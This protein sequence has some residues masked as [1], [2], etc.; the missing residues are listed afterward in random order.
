MFS[1]FEVNVTSANKKAVD[2]F[3]PTQYKRQQYTKLINMQQL[4]PS[5]GFFQTAWH[6]NK[7]GIK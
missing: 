4:L 1:L 5:A 2:T 3:Y 6:F 7:T